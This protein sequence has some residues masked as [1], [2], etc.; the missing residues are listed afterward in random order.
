MSHFAKIENGFVIDIIVAEQEFID[1][2]AVGSPSNWV[3]TSYNTL[4]G[5]HYEPNVYPLTPSLDQSKALRKNY[6]GIGY[7]YDEDRDAFIAPKPF[8]SWLLNEDTCQWKAPVD[9][10]TDGKDYIWNEDD[11]MWIEITTA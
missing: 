3:K 4:G 10:P 8:P 1:S 11:I 9:Y 6:A 5:V 7:I 2:G